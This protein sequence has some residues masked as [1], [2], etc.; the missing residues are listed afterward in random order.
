MSRLVASRTHAKRSGA[1]ACARS[2]DA[3]KA[4]VAAHAASSAERDACS[5]RACVSAWFDNREA[6]LAELAAGAK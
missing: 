6:Q 4:L 5:D 1:P 2:V 3:S